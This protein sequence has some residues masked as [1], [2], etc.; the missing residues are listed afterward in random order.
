MKAA[1]KYREALL[2]VT[3]VL[4]AS[5][6]GLGVDSAVMLEAGTVPPRAVFEG[7]VPRAECDAGSMTESA[8]QGQVPMSDRLSQ[9]T[10]DGYRCNLE[11]VGQ[12]GGS[13]AAYQAAYYEDCAYYT[14]GE[15]KGIGAPVGTPRVGPHGT[16]V[17]DVR[18]STNPQATAYLDTPGM[19]DPWESLKTNPARRLVGGTNGTGGGGGPELDLY[20]ISV[21]CRAP[22][23]ISTTSVGSARGHAGHFTPDGLTYYA[24]GIRAIDIADPQSPQ[25]LLEGFGTTHDLSASNDGNRLYIT[26]PSCG[27][28]L[29][30][31][32]VSQVQARSPDPATNV[33]GEV[34]WSDGSVAQQTQYMTIGGRP[35]VLFTDEGGMGAQRII[36]I[37]D[38][39]NPRVISKLKLEIHMEENREAATAD[40]AVLGVLVD[41]EDIPTGLIQYDGHYCALSDGKS[42]S[43]PYP[44]ENAAI[45][46]CANIWS[47]VRVFDIRDP[48][49]PREIAYFIAPADTGYHE[50]SNFF[51]PTN[52]LFVA[53]S[54]AT[55]H[56]KVDR[57]EIWMTSSDGGFHVVRFTRPLAELLGPAPRISK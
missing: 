55:P 43:T 18:E 50:G 32:D 4:L 9:R 35:Y 2:G 42:D 19:L 30:I 51:A 31:V 57:N 6:C 28:G 11:Q 3:S 52:N 38:E 37:S 45:A 14:T 29:A 54:G 25:L 15:A 20:D 10:R 48:Y 8:L 17:V 36:D 16:V 23:L 33:L 44:V 7:P 21:D 5:G 1:T 12:F 34:C 39:A 24:T 46:V 49:A 27:N 47:G 26:G 40:G 41:Q 56:L 22:R 53:R 13:G